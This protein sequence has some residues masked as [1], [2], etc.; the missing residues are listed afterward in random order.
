MLS[1]FS[2]F[3][4]ITDLSPEHLITQLLC[5]HMPLGI[6]QVSIYIHAAS[7]TFMS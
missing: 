7:D 2:S 6:S 4:G 3:A 1:L 5:S